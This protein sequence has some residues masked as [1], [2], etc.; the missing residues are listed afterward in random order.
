MRPSAQKYQ[1]ELRRNV[2]LWVGGKQ[3]FELQRL[4]L[5]LLEAVPPKEEPRQA[6]S[7]NGGLTGAS[8]KHH[9]AA[10]PP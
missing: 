8:I 9:R 3:V 5:V 6:P 1:A 4:L 7:Y 2:E 10:F